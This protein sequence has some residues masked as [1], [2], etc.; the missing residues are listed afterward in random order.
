M[1]YL[2]KAGVEKVGLYSAYLDIN[3]Q[4]EIDAWAARYEIDGQ[5]L[6]VIN[7]LLRLQATDSSVGQTPIQLPKAANGLFDDRGILK[8]ETYCRQDGNDQLCP[9]KSAKC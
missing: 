5:K 8:E 6:Q 3:L 9:R 2:L 4:Q 7:Q 1:Q